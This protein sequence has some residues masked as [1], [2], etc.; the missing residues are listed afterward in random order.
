VE[1]LTV[2]LPAESIRADIVFRVQRQG[3]MTV[4]LH[5]EFQGRTSRPR[6][7]WRMLDYVVR[8]AQE[9]RLPIHSAVLYLDQGAGSQD[10]GRH[11]HLGADG[12][13]MLAWSYQ[14]VHLWQM[15]AEE[16]LALGRR[17]LLPLVGLTK[18]ERPTE[19]MTQVVAAIR[20]EPDTER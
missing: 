1:L 14:V 18:I 20:A 8:L 17:S 7:P 5:I 2:E 16:L 3:G 11:E 4:V 6:M 9:H 13:V 12:S 15:R 10:T 19:T